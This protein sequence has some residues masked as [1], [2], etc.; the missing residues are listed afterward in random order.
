[1]KI[2]F[3]VLSLLLMLVLIMSGCTI[4]NF[5]IRNLMSS[6]KLTGEKA[7][8]QNAIEEYE[9]KDIILM[10]PKRGEYRSAVIMRDTLRNGVEEAIAFYST[11][12]DYEPHV[13][14]LSK[15]EE[16]CWVCLEDFRGQGTD[17]DKVC[18][19][20]VNNDGIE[21][22]ILGWSTYNN[23]D[24]HVSI[25]CYNN[26]TYKDIKMSETYT[27]FLLSDM[28]DDGN[29]EI[30][31]L[32]LSSDSAPAKAQLISIDKESLSTNTIGVIEMDPDVIQYSSVICGNID[33]DKKG[34]FVDSIRSG[35]T[36]STEIIYWDNNQNVLVNPLHKNMINFYDAV[37]DKVQVR[38][39]DIDNDGIIEIP[40]ATYG[41]G[42][43]NETPDR[44]SSAIICWLKYKLNDESTYLSMV[45]ASDYNEYIFK[46]PTEWYGYVDVSREKSTNALI[47]SEII[48]NKDDNS[49][50]NGA[51]I[52]KIQ[53][54][55]DSQLKKLK[56]SKEEFVLLD[57][58]GNKYYIALIYEKNNNL[59]IG[60]DKIKDCF[61]LYN[62]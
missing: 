41:I 56:D 38:S 5:D 47:F 26:G 3:M 9:G 8:I 4:G 51:D 24:N 6:P 61:V 37:E 19:A 10:Y 58:R 36:L 33:K 18:F 57:C 42:R 53:A 21:E 20:D 48:K 40:K 32:S 46:M 34:V 15:N 17:I 43:Y 49:M 30:L 55:S 16:N 44:E 29:N 23:K 28:N 35:N 22:V 52:L 60:E 31:L 7:E 54:V 11:K 2:K 50:Y 1:M 62:R 25:Y 13:I 39:M 45:T 59:V 27:D 14:M 12:T